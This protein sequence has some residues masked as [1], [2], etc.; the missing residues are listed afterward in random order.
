VIILGQPLFDAKGSYK[1][2]SLASYESDFARL[3]A[4]F[5]E[6]LTETAAHK[7]HDILILTGDIH[8][9]RYAAATL[10]GR[11]PAAHVHEFVTSPASRVGPFITG[12]KP[13]QAPAN[14]SFPL[15]AA[16][17]KWEI[18]EVE[19]SRTIDDNI[20][21]VRMRRWGD[22]IQF[23]LD[24]WRVRTRDSRP[25]WGRVLRGRPTEGPVVSIFRKELLL[26]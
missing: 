10:V 9:G 5:E 22:R 13:K 19:L 2:R 11:Q 25:Y 15:G 14:F 6:S 26:R 24:L 8:T 23:E 1:D 7:A 21:A 4:I 3:C 12:I 20:A 18:A 16:K 17:Q